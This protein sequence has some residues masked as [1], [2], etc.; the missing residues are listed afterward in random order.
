MIF[1]TVSYVFDSFALLAFFR[2]EV[3]ADVVEDMLR[4]TQQGGAHVAIASVN[5]GEVAYRTENEFGFERLEEV[6]GKIVELEVDIVDVDRALALVAARH[7]AIY[8]MSYADCIATAL[9]QRLDV[10]LVTG[11]PDFH[12]VE[13]RVT[14]EWLPQDG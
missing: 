6:L 11:D 12:Q 5:L 3:A 4:S 8:K 2:D 9:A 1:S 10:P 14:V 13:H 7:R